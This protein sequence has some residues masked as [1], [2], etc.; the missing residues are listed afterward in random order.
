M[1]PINV[2]PMPKSGT[3]YPA[4]LASLTRLFAAAMASAERE[5]RAPR[6][7]ATAM[8]ASHEPLLL[9][10]PEAADPI[11]CPRCSL[12]SGSC[13]CFQAVL[14][15]HAGLMH[16]LP[17][18]AFALRRI[19]PSAVKRIVVLGPSHMAPFDGLGRSPF[20]HFATP[21]G[22]FPID[23][24]M[25]PEDLARRMEN[26]RPGECAGEHSLE[27]PMTMIGYML[28][29]RM[30]P[31]SD[32]DGQPAADIPIVPLMVGSRMQPGDRPTV[33][34]LLRDPGTLCVVSSDFCHYGR[35]FR[36]TP[37]SGSR[38]KEPIWT[39]IKALDFEYMEAISQ[40]DTE[41]LEQLMESRDNTVCGIQ[42]IRLFLEAMGALRPEA[43][44]HQHGPA[45]T[46]S[47]NH[48]D[49]GTLQFHAYAQ[50][51]VLGRPS[52][53]PRQDHSVSYASASFQ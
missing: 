20:S 15:P 37:F 33:A 43:G 10:A 50:S 38:A 42:P 14:L 3:W 17:T 46:C 23:Y 6:D 12:P 16:C 41:R 44:C 53:D 47:K 45:D 7:P 18:A 24:S 28:R 31:S 32:L 4:D 49:R 21:F 19:D 5:I 8:P 9:D 29:E 39:Q 11:P 30:S 35:S 40:A 2:R 48:F 1:S 26:L 52:A 36:F 27:L 25:I 34:A 51:S 22:A 13:P